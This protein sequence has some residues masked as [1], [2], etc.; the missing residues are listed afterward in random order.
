MI[1]QA[2]VP[3][4][5]VDFVAY[6]ARYDATAMLGT[7]PSGVAGRVMVR[8]SSW[9]PQR[10][11]QPLGPGGVGDGG[12]P[13]RGGGGGDG[14]GQLRGVEGGRDQ[15]AVLGGGVEA[16]DGVEV[17]QAAGLELGHLG[18]RQLHL[19]GPG[20]LGGAGQLAADRDGGAAPQFGGVRVPDDGGG[21]VVAVRAQRPSQGGVG[22]FVPLAAG[23]APPVLAE[24]GFAAGAASGGPAAGQLAAGVHGP[25]AGGGEGGEHARMRPHRVGDAFA[26]GEPGADQLV[27][28]PPVGLGAGRADARRGGPRTGCRSPCPAG[29]RCRGCGGSRRWPGPGRGSCRGAGRGGRSRRWRWSRRAMVVVVAGGAVEQFV[30]EGPS[31]APVPVRGSMSTG[32]RASAGTLTWPCPFTPRR[33]RASGGVGVCITVQVTVQARH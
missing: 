19:P 24:G 21:V 3:T 26:A 11:S 7:W 4:A 29:C 9:A 6:F 30:V 32:A 20:S 13:R 10:M 12:E 5:S 14:G 1:R 25:E 18:I 16:E 17:D 33:T 2:M 31:F 23:Q 27:G 15:V 28:V 22:V 8:V